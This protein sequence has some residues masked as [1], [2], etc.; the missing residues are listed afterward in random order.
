MRTCSSVCWREVDV[1]FGAHLI[2]GDDLI[3][4]SLHLLNQSCLIECSAVGDD[5]HC[6]RHLQRRHLNVPLADR[7]VCDV[8]IENFATVSRLHVF[9]IRNAAFRF[10]AQRD[11]AFRAEAEL[12]RPINDWRRAGLYAGLIKPCVTRFSE[13]LHEI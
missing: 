6:L 12:Q 5:A 13:G 8:A 9:V 2:R 3:I 4:E 7:H 1:S 10:A 11:T